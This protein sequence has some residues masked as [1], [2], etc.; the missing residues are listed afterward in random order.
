AC[1]LFLL[2]RAELRQTDLGRDVVPG[3]FDAHADCDFFRIDPD[4]IGVHAHALVQ[5][6]DG[7]HVGHV[8]SERWMGRLVR[9]RTS[10]DPTFP[11]R[12]DPLQGPD[13]ETLGPRADV[14]RIENPGSTCAAA[15]VSGRCSFAASQNGRLTWDGVGRGFLYSFVV[16]I[17]VTPWCLGLSGLRMFCRLIRQGRSAILTMPRRSPAAAPTAARRCRR[18]RSRRSNRWDPAPG[19]RRRRDGSGAPPR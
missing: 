7:E 8:F 13:T 4:H 14:A 12:L 16:A 17:S 15:L 11:A 5:L 9:D 18:S 3:D 19:A 10:V 2:D 1:E 6:D